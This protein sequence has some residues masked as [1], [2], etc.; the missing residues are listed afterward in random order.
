MTEFQRQVDAFTEFKV[1]KGFVVEGF[2]VKGLAPLATRLRR[3]GL[4]TKLG[5]VPQ[6]A[7]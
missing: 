1:G 5:V 4:R 2:V 7:R 6:P 3:I